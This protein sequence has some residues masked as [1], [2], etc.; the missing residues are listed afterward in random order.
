MTPADALAQL[1]GVG[2]YSALEAAGVSRREV[3]AAVR[4]GEITR[5][6]NGWFACVG[7]P[8]EMVRAVRV[9]GSLTAGSVA[10]LHGLWTMPDSRLHVRVALNASRLSSADGASPLDPTRHGVCVHYRPRLP[11]TAV[12]S[13][14]RAL[15]EMFTC[16]DEVAAIVSVES[17]LNSGAFPSWRLA[18]LRELILPSKRASLAKVDAGGQSGLETIV[19]LLMRSHGVRCRTQVAIFGVGRVDLLIGDR[20]V[21]ELDGREFHGSDFEADRRRDWELTQRGYHVV[22]ISYS[23]VMFERERVEEGLLALVRRG[24]HLWRYRHQKSG[25]GR[26]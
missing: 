10:R 23:M 13:L 4:R 3:L 19:R 25:A 14:I 17:A 1:S 2:H 9:G 12:D 22:R 5:V 16:V 24:D 26:R 15:A 8:V 11:L 21:V 7:A 20:L 6:R 18:E